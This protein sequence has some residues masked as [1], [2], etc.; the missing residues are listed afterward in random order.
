MHKRTANAHIDRPKVPPSRPDASKQLRSQRTSTNQSIASSL[1]VVF[2]VFVISLLSVVIN[3]DASATEGPAESSSYGMPV[4][5]EVAM[6]SAMP[7]PMPMAE[8]SDMIGGA[9]PPP[10]PPRAAKKMKSES[11]RGASAGSN[12]LSDLASST[13]PEPQNTSKMLIKTGSVTLS[14]SHVSTDTAARLPY[15]VVPP[16]S[17]AS[18]SSAMAKVKA[19]VE[20]LSGAF[21]ESERVSSY[22]HYLQPPPRPHRYNS[23]GRDYTIKMS[24][25]SLTIKIPAAQ[26]DEFV[27]TLKSGKYG[28]GVEVQ[29]SSF[30]SQVRIYVERKTRAGR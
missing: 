11:S 27:E 8:R 29:E 16:T 10:P 15:L 19:A 24:Q 9:P 21:V 2:V 20:S 12:Y 25:A 17:H 28:E 7:M 14:T 18:F 13:S 30:S 22:N 26:Y 5:G 4:A 1:V 3:G 23:G 6:A